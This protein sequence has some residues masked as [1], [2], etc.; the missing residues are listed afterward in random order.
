MKKLHLTTVLAL[1]LT[2]AAYAEQPDIIY[3][4]GRPV[5][6]KGLEPA[7][8][9]KNKDDIA[10]KEAQRSNIPGD[11]YR[12]TVL[13]VESPN[14]R[15]AY[16]TSKEKYRGTVLGSSSDDIY[17]GKVFGKEQQKYESNTLGKRELAKTKYVYDTSLVRAI[18]TGDADRVRTLIYANVDINE[19]N[20]AGITPLT[21]AAEKGHLAIVKLLLEEGGASVNLN[22]SYGV[23]PLIAA[24]A[25]GHREV[26]DLL[27][28]NGADP[29]AKDDL[30]KTALLHAMSSDDAKLT[31]TL[32]KLNSRAINLPDN[33]GNTPLIYAAQKGH[34]NNI[35]VLLKYKAN[36]KM[37][38]YK[39]NRHELLNDNAREECTSDILNFIKA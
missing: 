9:V 20:Y 21:I 29:T 7:E 34:V 18:K 14:Q 8:D 26:A 1:L 4:D 22:S 27:L 36:V 10:L 35:K 33:D 37:K 28:K 39:N 6:I 5:Y 38:L 16:G 11:I 19:R 24:A 13:G 2:S 31:E 32:V 25:A 12:G 15:A 3:V 23:T 30:G 17:R